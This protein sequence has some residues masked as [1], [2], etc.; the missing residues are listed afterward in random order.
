MTSTRVAIIGAGIGGL[1]LARILQRQN[2]PSIVF[3][4]YDSDADE[5]V[6]AT[7]GGSLDLKYE[8]GQRA[9][10]DAGLHAEF[11]K[12]CRPIGEQMRILDKTGKAFY[13]A[14][15][16]GDAFYNPEIDRG[17]LRSLLLESLEPNTVQ[18]GRK[19]TAVRKDDETG[20]YSVE[21]ESGHSLTDVDIVVGADG[22][23]SRVRPVVWPHSS[24]IYSGITFLETKINTALHR[25]FAP[26]VGPGA[27]FALT[28]GKA[29][30]AQHNS[31]DL[32]ML[33]S[34]V[35]VPEDWATTSAVALANTPD[36]K[37]SLML[38]EFSDWDESLK[39]LIRAGDSPIIRPIY[40]LPWESE[41]RL[42]TD[43]IVLLGDAAHLMSPFAGE[44]VN[45]AMADAADLAKALNNGTSLEKYEK[46]MRTR[47]NTAG[48]ESATNL[49]LFFGEDAATKVAALFK[50]FEMPWGVSRLV[51]SYF[52]IRSLFA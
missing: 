7:F 42:K 37:L 16:N 9:L 5:M 6:R 29:I 17:Q 2:N 14:T 8:S 34:A 12:L 18:W 49:D 35:R 52:Y 41:P 3:T 36:E 38:K 44:G 27:M 4:I 30:M 24:P 20:K 28:D 26:L 48:K 33:Y 10:H 1:T 40:A 43:N 13:E 23:W 32:M 46:V 22:A 47:A 19:A 51:R 31:G 39:A 21:F 50:S 15:D 25:E 11:I 45:L